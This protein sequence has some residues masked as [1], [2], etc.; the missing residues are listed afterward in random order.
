MFGVGLMTS[1]KRCRPVPLHGAGLLVVI[2]LRWPSRSISRKCP[3]VR[4]ALIGGQKHQIIVDITQRLKDEIAVI[5][6]LKRIIIAGYG[7]GIIWTTSK[8]RYGQNERRGPASRSDRGSCPAHSLRVA[9]AVGRPAGRVKRH[10]SARVV[11]AATAI[12]SGMAAILANGR[13]TSISAHLD[14]RPDSGRL[15]IR[16]RQAY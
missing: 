13:N 1:N 14:V 8:I 4:S 3:V 2:R 11:A 5:Y 6:L 15:Q 16:S 7:P 12:F 9:L 10:A